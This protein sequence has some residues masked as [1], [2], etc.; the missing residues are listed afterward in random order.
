MSNL[1]KNFVGLVCA[2]ILTASLAWGQL[3]T[4]N[5][6]GTV[7]DPQ[8][9]QVTGATV[10]ITNEATN[11][12]RTQT[13]SPNGD[14]SFELIPPGEYKVEI[15][16]PGF[17]KQVLTVRA[18][19]GNPTDASAQ[20]ELGESTQTVIVEGSGREVQIN[21]QDASLGNTFVSQQITQL[22]L[23]SRNVQALLTL[24]PGVTRD[25]YVAGARNDQ[26]NI[27]LDGVDINEAQTNALGTPVLRLNSEAIEE[28]RVTTVGSNANQGRSSAAQINLVTKSGTNQFHASLFEFHRNTIFTA[29]DFF[30]NR[31]LIT[32]ADGSQHNLPRPKLIRNT[33]GA[34][35]GGP[36]KKDKLFFFY[37]YEGRRDAAETPAVRVVPLPSMGQGS[38]KYVASGGSVQTLTLAQLQGS[39]GVFPQ[40]GINPAALAALADAARKYPANDFTVGDSVFGSLRNTA[41]FRFN[42]R[43]PVNLNSHVAKLDWTITSKQTAYLRINNIYDH[44]TQVSQFPDTPSPTVWSHPW[45]LVGSHTWTIS[46]KWVNNFRYGITRQ[47]TTTGADST[48]NA[49]SFRFIFS[50]NLFQRKLDRVTPVHNITNDTSWMKG[51][52]TF[53]FGTNIRLIR[54]SRISFGSA[55]DSAITNPSFYAQAGAVVSD[56]IDAYVA[57]NNLPAVQSGADAQNAATALIGRYTQYTARFSFAH[58]GS[59]QP[60]GTPT[61]RNFATEEYDVYFQDAWKIRRNLTLSYG[62]RYGL[63]KPVYETQGFETKPD[64]PL[65]EFFARRVAGAA[66]GTPY[67]QQISLNLSG[68]ANGKSPM[69]N[70]D[71]DNFQPRV[72]IAWSPNFE[73]G[74]LARFFGPGG[75]SVIR[76]GYA[77]TN[78]YYGEALAVAF[79]LNNTLGFTQQ[80]TVSANT[81][82]ITN[83]LGPR[84]SGYT[85]NVHNL[86]LVPK[87]GNLTFPV[88][89]PADFQRR[90]E[91]SLDAGLVAPTE[92]AWNLT[93]ERELPAGFVLQ[94]SYL[95]R[96]GVNLLST[97]DVA[98]LNNLRDPKSGMDWYTAGTMLEQIRQTRPP[99]NTAVT[100]IPYFENIFPANLA[101]IMNSFYDGACTDI[102]GTVVPCIPAGFT[103]T[104]TVFWIARNFYANDWTSFQDDV[105]QATGKSY[106][107]NPQYGALS[108]WG[109]IANSWYN[110]LAVSLRQRWHDVSWD[111]N[112]TF[113]HS[114]DDASGL[115]TS[116]AYASIL[117]P[118]RQRDNYASSDFDVRHL[119]NINAVYQLPFGRNKLIASGV[120]RGVDAVIGGWQLSGIFRW[121]TGLPVSAPYDDSR[122]ATNWNVQSNTTPTRPVNTC[123]TKGGTGTPANPKLFG[124]DPTGIYQSFRN[125]YPGETGQRNI[126][127]LP[128]FA[129]LDLGLSKSITMPWNEKQK[130]ALRWEVFNVANLQRMGTLDTSRTGFGMRSDPAVR[131]RVPPSNWSNFTG[132]QGSPRVMQIGARF[133][134]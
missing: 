131:R 45:G 60:A 70:W 20:L 128:G 110:G 32:A 114:L 30:N 123:V 19:V 127:R 83:N 2:L 94:A 37:S 117:N 59:V 21:T 43:A 71:K 47:A 116:T 108:S 34:A 92:H 81:Y 55:F 13:T 58:D 48:D 67:N 64:I 50:P 14:Y 111:L 65:N 33:F 78:D 132:I 41:G 125:A 24:Q 90:I 118:I 39:N 49:I 80:F 29:N 12:T 44:T 53:Q 76:A 112:Y 68:P 98:A 85:Q 57:K 54:N 15:A 18:L 26:S 10:T 122:W 1:L 4:S 113:S 126:F 11:N 129:N 100:P 74:P 46:N 82:N 16:A 61:N 101:A 91:S 6:R 8:G 133:E 97:R 88:K 95:G 25:G 130:L 106:F 121:N 63:S 79:D 109:T 72:A 77:K 5:I 38:L 99:A 35:F 36:I 51:S 52:H 40:A 3:G 89:Q 73:S 120:S 31:T 66:S 115:Q 22:P 86:P 17:R 96:R 28:F 9:K 62:L 134:F 56:A 102:A 42:A 124:C 103:P 23:E 104:Q 69:Y 84:F 93:F 107:Y 7:T 87:V 105:E 119:I 27:T 75:K